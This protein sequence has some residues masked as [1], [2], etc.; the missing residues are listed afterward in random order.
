MRG[1]STNADATGLSPPPVAGSAD[2]ETTSTRL[3]SLEK[4]LLDVEE[5]LLQISPAG[6]REAQLARIA[7][8]E[9]ACADSD[10]W[11]DPSAATRLMRELDSLRVDVRRVQE[12][13]ASV[14]DC[15]AAIEMVGDAVG[16]PSADGEGAELLMETEAGVVKIVRCVEDLEVMKLLSGKYDAMGAVVTIHAGAGGDDAS[17]WASI[18]MRMYTRWAERRDFGVKTTELSTG[19]VAGI[20]SCCIEIAG[21]FAYGYC[22]AEK[23]THR[24]VRLSPFSKASLRHTSFAS[25]EVMPLLGDESDEG[26]GALVINDDDIEVTTMRSGGAGGQNVNE[27]RMQQV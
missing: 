6:K 2:G 15:R 27:V 16:E 19:D 5:R 20:K 12:M 21:P 1:L 23:G 14:A 25:V 22:C 3:T 10:L 17:D 9:A 26:D 7:E 13:L 11:N 18:L 24:L 8:L 4:V